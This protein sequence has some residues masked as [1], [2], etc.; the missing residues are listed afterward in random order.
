MNCRFLTDNFQDARSKAKVITCCFWRR[1]AYTKKIIDALKKCKGIG[2]YLILIQ[3]DGADSKGDYGQSVVRNICESIDFAEARIVSESSHLGCNENTRR[4]L[5]AG[6]VHSDY[7]IHIED[8]V[9]VA[10]DALSYFE[11]ARQ[12]GSDPSLFIVSAWRHPAGWKPLARKPKP[13]N[14]D[15]HCRNRF[16]VVDMGIRNMARSVGPDAGTMDILHQRPAHLMG[17]P[18]E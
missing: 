7:V 14:Q 11:W 16:M 18:S 9:M 10:P 3:Q 6:F 1:P 17:L 4:A 2:E 12:F 13:L 15:V 5:A 8:D